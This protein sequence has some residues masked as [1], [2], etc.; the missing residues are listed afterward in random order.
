M[1]ATSHYL[2][3]L[4]TFCSQ[5]SI[6]ALW[7]STNP[8]ATSQQS[9]IGSH[10]IEDTRGSEE[11]RSV[12]GVIYISFSALLLLSL[13]TFCALEQMMIWGNDGIS[14]FLSS[15]SMFK[16]SKI[17]TGVEKRRGWGSALMNCCSPP[18]SFCHL[19]CFACNQ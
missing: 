7:K 8:E 5:F 15:P 3:F 4:L 2:L 18:P 9:L 13:F 19:L 11:K 17:F 10:A 1:G 6:S 16:K 12:E 14:L